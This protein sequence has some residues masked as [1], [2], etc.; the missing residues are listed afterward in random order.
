MNKLKTLEYNFIEASTDEKK[1]EFFGNLMPSI[2][3][4]RRKPG[5]L[6][7]RPLRKLYTPSEKVSEYVKKNV[8]DIGEIDGTYVFLHRW[9]THGFDPVVFEETKMFIYRLNR[10]ISKQGIKGQALYPLS[11]RINLPKLAAS[12]GLGTL[13]PFGLLVH[14]EFGPRLFITAL[15]GADVL[16][17]RNLP[18]TSG[19][20]SCNKC[21]EVCPQNPQ[22]T[23]TVNLGLCRACSKCISECPVGI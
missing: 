23:K 5:R 19:C 10:I 12:A 21:V 17:S 15:K 20:T 3:L 18:K 11:P 13:S 7:L 6:L 4:F 8:D 2:I 14:P 1:I 16:L 9:K 22:Q